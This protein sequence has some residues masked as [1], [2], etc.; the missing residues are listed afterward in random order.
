[1]E[2]TKI[3]VYTIDTGVAPRTP[4]LPPIMELEVGQSILFSLDKRNAVQVMASRVKKET[5][6]KF[7]I[8]KQDEQ[9][10]R[11]WRVE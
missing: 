5:G 7:K 6:R 3:P 10:A 2:K 4:A 8:Q 9:S 1:M 11:I